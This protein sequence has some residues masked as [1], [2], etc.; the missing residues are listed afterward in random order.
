V[1]TLLTWESRG[2]PIVEGI[3][4]ESA[5][6]ICELALAQFGRV[7][8]MYVGSDDVL[9]TIALDFDAGTDVAEA[10][11]AVGKVEQSVG[12]RSSQIKRL[13]IEFGSAL[14]QQ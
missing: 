1:A 3:C 11:A 12:E 13:F 7:L 6:A 5:L 2:L 4:P 8:S 10:A 14:M 9:V